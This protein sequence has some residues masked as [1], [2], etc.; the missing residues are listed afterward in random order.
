MVN[1]S[2]RLSK[3]LC[4]LLAVIKMCY[5]QTNKEYTTGVIIDKQKKQ[6][7]VQDRSLR[8]I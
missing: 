3:I 4:N 2:K 7:W 6:H 1:T 5:L 8:Y